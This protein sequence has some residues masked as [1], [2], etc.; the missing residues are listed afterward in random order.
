MFGL[1]GDKKDQSKNEV[2][3]DLEL[4]IQDVAKLKEKI[5]YIQLRMRQLK[6]ILNAGVDK[7]EMGKVAALLN[8]YSA[9]FKVISR[10]PRKKTK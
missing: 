1:E 10:K 4:E 6:D 7:E 8:G 3:F 5:Q 2:F 9:L